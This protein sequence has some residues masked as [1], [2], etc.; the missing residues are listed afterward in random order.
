MTER[1]WWMECRLKMKKYSQAYATPPALLVVAALMLGAMILLTPG[2][3]HAE[4]SG[5]DGGGYWQLADE[6]DETTEEGGNSP[7]GGSSPSSQGPPEPFSG[8]LSRSWSRNSSDYDCQD[9]YGENSGALSA[10]ST[11]PFLCDV[12]NEYSGSNYGMTETVRVDGQ[13]RTEELVNLG[14]SNLGPASSGD[15]G[16]SESEEPVVISVSLE[17]F[18]RM[19][20]EPLV[21]NA[22]PPDGWVPVNMVN[23]LYAEAEEQILD[24]EIIGTPVQVRATPVAYHWD[25]GDGNTINTDKP[26]E[27]Y[28]SEQVSSEYTYEG[29]YD[30]TLTTTFEGEFS[31]NGGEWQPIDGT[32]EVASEPI[33]IFAK[34]FESRLVNP[35]VP[36]DEEK[37]PYVP[38][39]TPD[40][41]GPQDPEA[42]HREI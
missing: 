11:A 7:G 35:E 27:P 29:W 34:S 36:V 26:G 18:A 12:A 31:V 39:R 38:E 17:E 33:E 21:A 13:A 30:I 28:P 2:V 16:G 10:C 3:V 23:V 37:D 24:V 6:L 5:S 1:G 40:T 32:I 19:P 22:G 8:L 20:V 14:C 15:E 9:L 42:R 25:L 41:E 4:V